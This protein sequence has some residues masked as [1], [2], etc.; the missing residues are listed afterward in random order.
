MQQGVE[1]HR[2]MAVGQY[3]TISVMPQR[4]AWV[5]LEK[6]SPKNFSNI[7][8]SHGGSRVTAVRRLHSIHG[9]YPDGISELKT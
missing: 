1:Q 8:K 9:Q 5:V 4:V 6:I 2:A 7:G 3:E